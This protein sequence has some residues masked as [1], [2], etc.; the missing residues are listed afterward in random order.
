MPHFFPLLRTHFDFL[1]SM[2]FC[3]DRKPTLTVYIT[4]FFMTHTCPFEQQYSVNKTK[5]K[6][7]YVNQLRIYDTN[8]ITKY[9]I[10]R[11]VLNLSCSQKMSNHRPRVP[12]DR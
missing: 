10:V 8:L 12:N 6:I 1:V 3:H 7:I 5:P 11:I 9:S 2:S 4:I